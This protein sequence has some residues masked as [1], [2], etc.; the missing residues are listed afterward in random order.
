MYP[1]LS[2]NEF[3][4]KEDKIFDLTESGLPPNKFIKDA[5]ASFI[6]NVLFGSP[7]MNCAGHGICEIIKIDDNTR[8]LSNWNLC[9]TIAQ[10]SRSENGHYL[11]K[12]LKSTV[13]ERLYERQFKASYFKVDSDFDIGAVFHSSEPSYIKN[14][15]YAFGEDENFIYIDFSTPINL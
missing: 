8:T 10:I 2:T 14:G 6:G 7:Q 3:F 4:R 9:R 12:V 15:F 13:S 5:R 11:I 1:I